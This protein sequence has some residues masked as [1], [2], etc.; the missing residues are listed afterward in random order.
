VDY[1]KEVLLEELHDNIVE[2]EPEKK[3]KVKK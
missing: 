1:Y 3:T 2:F